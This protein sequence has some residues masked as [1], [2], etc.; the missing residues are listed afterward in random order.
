MG[1]GV[2]DSGPPEQEDQ[3]PGAAVASM[4]PQLTSTRDQSL[5]TPRVRWRVRSSLGGTVCFRTPY[6]RVLHPTSERKAACSRRSFS[7]WQKPV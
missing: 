4:P 2:G 1:V 3:R 7:A 6:E 5:D